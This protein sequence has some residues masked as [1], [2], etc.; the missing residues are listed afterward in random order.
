M[1]EIKLKNGS[2]IRIARVD[3]EHERLRGSSALVLRRWIE[4]QWHRLRRP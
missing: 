4:E 2:F 1:M 3:P